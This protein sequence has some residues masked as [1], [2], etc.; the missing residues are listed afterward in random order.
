MSPRKVWQK[1]QQKAEV[2]PLQEDTTGELNH[3]ER[4]RKQE[5]SDVMA[6]A[7]FAA[8][9]CGWTGERQGVLG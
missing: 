4:L 8:S 3:G 2:D 7:R 6:W 1:R 5:G 9:E